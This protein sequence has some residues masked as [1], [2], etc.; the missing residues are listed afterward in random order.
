MIG[1][2]EALFD[3]CVDINE[4]VLAR[5]FP[6]VQQHVPH[7]GIGTLAVLNDF[8]EVAPQDVRQFIDFSARF[9]VERALQDLLQF[10]N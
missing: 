3:N 4:P 10:I 6:R 9:V 1:E 5:T 8:V 7:D 2:I